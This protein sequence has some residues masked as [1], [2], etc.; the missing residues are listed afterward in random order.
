MSCDPYCR[1]TCPWTREANG[2]G[3]DRR[4]LGRDRADD[5]GARV[6]AR[7]KGRDTAFSLRRGNRGKET[8]RGLRIEQH[9]VERARGCLL[10]IADGAAQ[11][12]VLRL[13]RGEDAGRQG[14]ARARPAAAAHRA[15]RPRRRRS[16]RSFPTRWPSRP[17]PVTSV[18]ACAPCRRRRSRRRARFDCVICASAAATQR[19]LALPRISPRAGCLCRCG[20]VRISTSP[21]RMPL[22]RRTPRAIHQTVD[23]EAERELGAF[24]GVSADQRAAGLAQELRWRRPSWRRGP[25]RPWP[26]AHRGSWRWRAPICGCAAHG[27]DVAER[28]VGGDLAEQ[29]GIVDDGAEII[30][31][32]HGKL[33][34]AGVDDRGVVRASRP[35]TTSSARAGAMPPR[36]RGTAPSLRPWRRSRRSASAMAENS[37]AAA[38]SASGE[39]G[40]RGASG[41]SGSALNRRMKR[42]SMQSFQRQ[43]QSPSTTRPL[44][45]ADGVRSPVETR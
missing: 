10:Q 24:A 27:K 18:A 15:P 11:A 4:A 17:K 1:G 7:L 43:T 26:P 41:I 36:A 5:R 34:P 3:F 9:R 14:F 35:T 20:L 38:L 31:G 12:H 45:V 30:D 6:A 2:Y 28:V 22:L 13:Q 40:P 42:R 37:S 32:L 39:V 23:G 21:A 19:A 8:A 44:R 16:L 33:R 25:P 29:I